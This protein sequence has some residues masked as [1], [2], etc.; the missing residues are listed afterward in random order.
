MA[1]IKFVLWNMEWLND[2]FTSDSATA[3]FK[4][5]T[6]STAHSKASV[7]KR[8]DE[9]RDV[10]VKLDPDCVVV[11]EGP[12][13]AAELD[14]FFNSGFTGTW[15]THLQ[16][17]RR[18]GYAS[19]Q[20]IGIALRTDRG[21][22]ASDPL[23]RFDAAAEKAFDD[24]EVDLDDDEVPERYQFERRPLYAEVALAGGARFRVLGLHLKSKGIFGAYEWSK[25]WAVADGNRRRILAQAG[26]LRAEFVE[27]YLRRADTRDVPLLVC[28]DI[29][30]GPGFDASE[31][32]LV[33]SGVERL[34]GT[35]WFP[36]LALRSALFEALPPRDQAKLNFEK[37]ATTRFG[38]PIF[39]NV[40]H[41][42]WIDHVLYTPTGGRRWVKEA[43]VINEVVAGTPIWRSHAD[44]SDHRPV[45]AT[46]EL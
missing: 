22:F 38:D 26:H 37:L 24:F 25:W 14:L 21:R 44:A 10:L 32:R 27:P 39:N 9:L 2:L 11:I 13:R 34:M 30:D 46:I 19:L 35:V 3:A 41:E 31:K 8:L 4:P 6:A 40:F 45:A 1:T 12:S 36:E 20:N 43:K 17:T 15:A 16:E 7:G 29:N 42:E 28:G 18:P 33:G 23:K 5:R